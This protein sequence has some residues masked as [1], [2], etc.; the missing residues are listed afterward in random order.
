MASPVDMLDFSRWNQ[1]SLQSFYDDKKSALG[2]SPMPP[3]PNIHDM[4]P[5]THQNLYDVYRGISTVMRDTLVGYVRDDRTSFLTKLALP[6]AVSKSLSVEWN[7]TRFHDAIAGRVPAEGMSRLLSQSRSKGRRELERRGISFFMEGDVLNDPT[8]GPECW[9][10]NLLGCSKTIQETLDYDVVFECLNCNKFADLWKFKWGVTGITYE[11][12]YQDEIMN[13]AFVAGNVD[14]FASLYEATKSAMES[15]SSGALPNL[16]MVWPTAQQYIKNIPP[17]NT[18]YWSVDKTGNPVLLKGPVSIGTFTDGTPIFSVREFKVNGQ[19]KKP[20]QLLR[21]SIR[22]AEYYPITANLWN[23]ENMYKYKSK[24]RDCYMYDQ[25]Q[26]RQVKVEFAEAIKFARIF[27][28]RDDTWDSEL[29][30]KVS[31]YNDKYSEE[32]VLRELKRM[33][34]N[35]RGVSNEYEEDAMNMDEFV[36]SPKPPVFPLA[37]IDISNRWVLPVIM[38]QIPFR[39]MHKQDVEDITRTVIAKFS[40]NPSEDVKMLNEVYSLIHDIESQPYNRHYFSELIKLNLENSLNEDGVFVGESTPTDLMEAWGR[41]NPQ[42][43]W[44]SNSHGTLIIPDSKDL[45]VSAPAGFANIPGLRLL[46]SKGNDKESKWFKL[47][48]RA[49]AAL[50]LL[51]R[52][53]NLLR[54]NLQDPL[55]DPLNRPLWFHRPDAVTTFFVHA[56]APNRDPVF[57]PVPQTKKT[58]KSFSDKEI[59][60]RLLPIFEVDITDFDARVKRAQEIIT[61]KSLDGFLKDSDDVFLTYVTPTGHRIVYPSKL[62]KNRNFLPK[63]L[64]VM[65]HLETDNDIAAFRS[66]VKKIHGVKY[67]AADQKAAANSITKK[68]INML[69]NNIDVE[70]GSNLNRKIVR[71]LNDKEKKPNQLI[72]IIETLSSANSSSAPQSMDTV[73]AAKEYRDQITS[74]PDKDV[75]PVEEHNILST[76]MKDMNESNDPDF[77]EKTTIE[78]KARLFRAVELLEEKSSDETLTLTREGVAAFIAKHGI[79]DDDETA[80]K[81]L[82]KNISKDAADSAVMDFLERT[83]K[84]KEVE[85]RDFSID[86]TATWKKKLWFRTPL[87]MS[88]ELLRTLALEM[89]PLALPGDPNSGNTRPYS[90]EGF[91]GFSGNISEEITN[92]FEYVSINVLKFNAKDKVREL[93][94]M[95]W[96]QRLQSREG[97]SFKDSELIVDKPEHSKKRKDRSVLELLGGSVEDVYEKKMRSSEGHS[98]AFRIET[99]DASLYPTSSILTSITMQRFK[100]SSNIMDPLVR[101][102]S[103]SFL[104]T[105]TR[106]SVWMKMISGDID[107]PLSTIYWRFIDQDMFHMIIMRGGFDTGATLIKEPVWAYGGDPATHTVLA[108]ITFWSKAVVQTPENVQPIFSVKPAEYGGGSNTSFIRSQNDL[109]RRGNRDRNSIIVTVVAR[110]EIRFPKFM[111]FTGQLPTNDIQYS[112]GQQVYDWS[113]MAC[114]YYGQ[115]YGANGYNNGNF[116]DD[117]IDSRGDNFYPVAA[118]GHFHTYN[119]K[120][121]MYSVVHICLG[122]RGRNGCGTGAAAVWDGHDAYFKEQNYDQLQLE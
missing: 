46:A 6:L 12:I 8:Y 1:S 110:T 65:I 121:G 34:Y 115:I 88:K 84:E 2:P 97:N 47:G 106:P 94:D 86:I 28:F 119:K 85:K 48:Q 114:D 62:A 18:A 108:A 95:P 96:V 79:T 37:T 24:W 69:Y 98:R 76:L 78:V 74:I 104:S 102:I 55:T 36:T 70:N 67:K 59:S 73:K 60:S 19:N 44:T 57:L 75:A 111:S 103:Y 11:K 107:V 54:T 27:N 52:I 35:N 31:E 72:S 29:I 77:D 13:F 66:V 22:F 15:K 113:Y 90:P 39:S 91:E 51:D 64:S 71:F 80:L 112:N 7:V 68:F 56:I 42:K 43:Q 45:T 32:E 17:T 109:T 81:E 25:N 38:G 116:Q 82:A 3:M 105:S 30:K 87:T 20:V 89:Y 14:R 41:S 21:S 117:D 23:K 99:K 40:E 93:T 9:N 4:T 5:T 118:P 53:V 83:E 58:G 63:D 100:E 101:V 49:Q 120:T 33:N 122:H 26:D 92:R 10:R 16:V 50:E 61:S